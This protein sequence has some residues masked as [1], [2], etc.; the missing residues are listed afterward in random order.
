MEA[1]AGCAAPPLHI[2]Q[3]GSILFNIS[4]PVATVGEMA[5][6]CF[7]SLWTHTQGR[8]GC[9]KTRNFVRNSKILIASSTIQ[10]KLRKI[11][12]FI[13]WIVLL[14]WWKVSLLSLWNCSRKIVEFSSLA[15]AGTVH[16]VF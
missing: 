16:A 14:E 11:K 15:D 4:E 7:K 2:V 3:K 1:A 6:I 5:Q 10:P 12:N 13:Q 8:Q 9:Q